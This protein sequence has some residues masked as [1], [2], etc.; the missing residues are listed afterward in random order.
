LF[1]CVDG[2]FPLEHVDDTLECHFVIKTMQTTINKTLGGI[3]KILRLKQL[4]G[5]IAQTWRM[6]P[7]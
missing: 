1:V 6:V 7:V 4:K 5:M 3:R 2:C